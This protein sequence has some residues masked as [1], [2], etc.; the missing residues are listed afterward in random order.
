MSS[1]WIR[2][3]PRAPDVAGAGPHP[4][5]GVGGRAPH[6][7]LLTAVLVL[8]VATTLGAPRVAASSA[9]PV[10]T[11]QAGH[12]CIVAGTGPGGAPTAGPATSSEL[13]RPNGAAVDSAGNLYIADTQ[14]NE[15]EKVT[16]LGTL[17]VVAGTGSLGA[18]TPGPATSSD[19][20]QPSGVAVNSA[21]NLY[22]ADTQNN[23][24]EKVTPSGTLSVVAGTGSLGAPTPG[25][26]TSSEL[27]QPSGVAVDSAGNLFIADQWNNVV[28]MVAIAA[29]ASETPA[30]SASPSMSP[31]PSSS[32][33]VNPTLSASTSVNPT[34]S[35]S[36]SVNPAPSTPAGPTSPVPLLVGVGVAILILA[37]ILVFLLSRRRRRS[38]LAV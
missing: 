35:A 21:G 7:A 5:G 28:E 31:A 12:L 13:S 36:T 24:V 18:P 23:V 15:V 10:C 4:R 11:T 29:S 8:L 34:P 37:G 26:A 14:N 17:S 38:G 19:L 2:R 16:P 32:T 33:S 30:P 9:G 22:I 20:N 27:N 25:P 6:L 3:R 1:K